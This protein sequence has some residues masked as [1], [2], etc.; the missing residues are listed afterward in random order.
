MTSRAPL[1]LSHV[2]V[3]CEVYVY[4]SGDFMS[5]TPLPTGARAA[6]AP[7]YPP[8]ARVPAMGARARLGAAPYRKELDSRCA[9]ETRETERAVFWGARR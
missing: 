5:V 1:L 6:C 9:N 7:K 3:S 4:G 2:I 8:E